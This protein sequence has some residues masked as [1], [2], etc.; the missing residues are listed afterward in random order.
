MNRCLSLPRFYQ[1]GRMGMHE[2]WHFFSCQLRTKQN[3]LVQVCC[4][5]K[6]YFLQSQLSQQRRGWTWLP[7][8]TLLQHFAAAYKVTAGTEQLRAQ[9]GDTLYV[10]ARRP[11]CRGGS[12]KKVFSGTASNHSFHHSCTTFLLS[13][14][15]CISLPS[16]P[17]THCPALSEQSKPI[18]HEVCFCC[19]NETSHALFSILKS[20]L[21]FT[22][23]FLQL[24]NKCLEDTGV[25]ILRQQ[26]E[27]AT[28]SRSHSQPRAA[29]I[30][31]VKPRPN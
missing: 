9:P 6:R 17:A 8:P 1:R 16:F 27:G 22:W 10:C 24:W 18:S 7:F 28:G 12:T 11:A 25:A 13:S 19:V 3:E 15:F 2:P 31:L 5:H 29:V 14:D 30:P 21:V 20:G 23:G 26:K 4:P